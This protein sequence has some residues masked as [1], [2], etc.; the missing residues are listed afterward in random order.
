MNQPNGLRPRVTIN[1]VEAEAAYGI[2]AAHPLFLEHAKEQEADP[3]ILNTF[4]FQKKIVPVERLCLVG[5]FLCK[6]FC[7]LGW[8][9]CPRKAAGFN[10]EMKS[11]TKVWKYLLFGK[12]NC[13]QEPEALV[14]QAQ[15]AMHHYVLGTVLLVFSGICAGSWAYV[16]LANYFRQM[17]TPKD[18]GW[19]PSIWEWFRVKLDVWFEWFVIFGS[20]FFAGRLF[21][22]PIHLGTFGHLLLLQAFWASLSTDYCRLKELRWIVVSK[23]S[24]L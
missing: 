16:A 22:L 17:I 5:R 21:A 24:W 1:T 14:T 8:S 9:C 18:L 23:G 4:S 10:W 2:L 19:L 12:Q 20:T 13:C 15:Q 11:R 6:S 7:R 3:D